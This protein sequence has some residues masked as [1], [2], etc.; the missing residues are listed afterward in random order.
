MG[1]GGFCKE[2][3]RYAFEDLKTTSIGIPNR[4]YRLRNARNT[5]IS[6]ENNDNLKKDINEKQF[7]SYTTVFIAILNCNPHSNNNNNNLVFLNTSITVLNN[8]LINRFL[9]IDWLIPKS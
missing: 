5:P 6:L 4:P 3:R 1:K 2:G 9:N 7:S 8:T